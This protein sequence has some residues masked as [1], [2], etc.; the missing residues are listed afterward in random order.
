MKM[1][2]PRHSCDLRASL[3]ALATSSTLTFAHGKTQNVERTTSNETAT[4]G[5]AK[6]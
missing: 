1:F 6:T 4:C 2:W 3:G 5:E